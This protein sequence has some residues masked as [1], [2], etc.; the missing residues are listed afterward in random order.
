MEEIDLKEVLTKAKE[1]QT[2]EKRWHFHMLTPDCLFNDSNDKH[3]LVLENT[4]DDESFFVYTDKRQL[5]IGKKLVQLLHG[6]KI[7]KQSDK[8]GPP[9]H[10]NI[11]KMVARA[12]D[13]NSKKISW[14]HH[15]FFPEC[16]YND[17]VGRWNIVMEDKDKGEL[18]EATYDTE[19]VEDL[20]EIERLYYEQKE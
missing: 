2:A 5:A 18:L 6:E 4:S 8:A 11:K 16:R 1:W 15:V 3:S 13:M 12:E 7:L 14:H 10:P 17:Q 19:P 20:K 9:Q